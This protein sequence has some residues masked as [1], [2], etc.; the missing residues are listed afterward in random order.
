MGRGA[1]GR[2]AGGVTAVSER[3]GKYNSAMDERIMELESRV[4]LQDRTIGDLDK[5]VRLFADR[6][7]RLERRLSELAD[8][9]RT[10]HEEVGPHDEQPPH[11]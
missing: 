2:T 10:D 8:K 3:E 7:E 9:L 6:V 1:V 11:Y 4:A 5:V